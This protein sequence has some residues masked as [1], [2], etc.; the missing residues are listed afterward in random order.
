MLLACIGM[1]G[2]NRDG[3]RAKPPKTVAYVD[4]ILLEVASAP[5]VADDEPGPD[6]LQ[7]RISFYLNDQPLP[8]AV[9]GSL[10]F[11]LYEGRISRGRLVEARP[12]YV[13]KFAPGDLERYAVRNHGLWGYGMALLWGDKAPLSDTVTLGARYQPPDAAPMYSRPVLLSIRQD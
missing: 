10:E 3:I 5:F 2:C 8:V 4:A 7:V 11:L 12:C 6:G 13:W 9:T 1:V